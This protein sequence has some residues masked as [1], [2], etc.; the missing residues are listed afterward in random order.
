MGTIG[1]ASV[2]GSAAPDSA[3]LTANSPTRS[4]SN[5][6]AD[7]T[8]EILDAVGQQPGSEVEVGRWAPESFS[9]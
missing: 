2:I 1:G 7:L 8:A 6:T 4:R 9:R 5:Q 3:Y